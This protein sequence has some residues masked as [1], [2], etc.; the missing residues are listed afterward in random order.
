MA[1]QEALAHT[2]GVTRDILEDMIAA[3]DVVKEAMQW[4]RHMQHLTQL[5]AAMDLTID[6]KSVV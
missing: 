2:I 1:V 5:V 4:G 6:R 3:T